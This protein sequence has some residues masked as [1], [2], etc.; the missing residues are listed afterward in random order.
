MR[1]MENMFRYFEL[2]VLLVVVL[3]CSSCALFGDPYSY[4]DD[5]D[6]MDARYYTSA[7]ILNVDLRS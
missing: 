2:L 4:R 5:P 1:L 6:F 7:R 3:F